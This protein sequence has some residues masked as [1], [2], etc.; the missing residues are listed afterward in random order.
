MIG[1]SRGLR[2]VMMAEQ[3]AMAHEATR[4]L[5]LGVFLCGLF[6]A[7]AARGCLRASGSDDVSL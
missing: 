7:Y 6:G 4:R 1:I 5:L 3:V 2:M